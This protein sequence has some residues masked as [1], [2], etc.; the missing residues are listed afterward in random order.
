MSNSPSICGNEKPY[1]SNCKIQNHGVL[2]ACGIDDKKI[3]Y[4]SNNT[5]GLF[6]I[7]AADLLQQSIYTVIE[8]DVV[9][10]LFNRLKKSKL[11]YKE[12][13]LKKQKITILVHKTDEHYIL[14]FE[15]NTITLNPFTYQMRL[16][17]IASEINNVSDISEKCDYVAAAFR[18]N[19]G[20]DRVFILQFDPQWNSDVIAEQKQAN[21]ESWLGFRFP[22]PI[23]A[24][25]EYQGLIK[26]GFTIN[27]DTASQTIDV[28]SSKNH[29]LT[30][31]HSVL[32]AAPSERTERL[33]NFE[34]AANFV[35]A[36]MH[37]N[38]L[39]G[40]VVCHHQTPK[41][42]NY[43]QRLSGA[44]F[45]QIL[46]TNIQLLN[47]D[48]VLDQVQKNSFIRSHLIDQI[49]LEKNVL[50]G[51]TDFEYT[52]NDLIDSEGAAVSLNG[53]IAMVGA[54]PS[55]NEIIKLIEKIKQL[56]DNHLYHTNYLSSVYKEAEAY[57]DVA[58]GV[59]CLVIS[60]RNNDA[61]LWFKPEVRRTIN[62]VGSQ[63]ENAIL[64]QNKQT[65]AVKQ[66][67]LSITE[68]L[69]MSEHWE[70]HEIAEGV[71]LHKSVQDI[72]IANY[73]EVKK[74]NDQ[75]KMAYEELES[76]SYS[77]SHDLRAP[78]RGI[79]GFA[80]ILKEDY[81][82]SLDDFGKSSVDTI[83]SSVTKMNMLID[84]IL[85]YSGL[86]RATIK[87][88]RFPL[89][90]LV[91][92]ILPDLKTL[93]GNVD[94]KI[95]KNLPDLV[96]DRKI[97]LLLVRNLLENAMKYSSKVDSPQVTI[98][99]TD[100]N[101]FFIKDNGIGFDMK[102]KDKIFGVFDRL[103]NEEYLGSGIGLAIAKRIVTK[104]QG[105]IWAESKRNLGS[106][107]Y[108]RLAINGE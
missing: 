41:Y 83:I 12:T 81:Y 72:I 92:E 2:I 93:Y 49:N 28:L 66:L 29:P 106:T 16:G 65:P 80:H 82:D 103:V 42:I 52:L 69:G 15:F 24:E 25:E 74:L 84:D 22:K 32:Q 55:K 102:H 5:Q 61:I 20:Y 45:T 87:H 18:E 86:G 37:D 97:V 100:E 34:V 23:G 57:K 30:M 98:G 70:N 77:I 17:E 26:K 44:F 76:F 99:C 60:S 104:H 64:N 85:E 63:E 11:S 54:C 88:R 9:A 79:D 8:E 13:V 68:Q 71:S 33:I 75:L 91:D 67:P 95:E 105:E 21:L 40:L 101:T 48:D 108:F 39:W 50:K 14:E 1:R 7:N 35:V 36:I 90:E 89:D 43:Y 53:K 10:D 56:T 96:G 73:D 6:D 59:L 51:L 19:F 94:V 38:L 62:W 3:N 4:A 107:F 58:S 31:P 47:T 78:L 46:A 27:S